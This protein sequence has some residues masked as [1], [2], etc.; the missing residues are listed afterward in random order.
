MIPNLIFCK[1]FF[2]KLGGYAANDGVGR[3]RGGNH[4][5]APERALEELEFRL[6]DNPVGAL[7]VD[8]EVVLLD[9]TEILGEVVLHHEH[10]LR[11]AH[12]P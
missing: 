3:E 12:F 9:S 8:T 4:L 7:L 5:V 2:Q 6:V 11:D 10:R 1:S